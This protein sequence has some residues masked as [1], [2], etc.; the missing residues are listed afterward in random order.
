MTDERPSPNDGD[1]PA[2]TALGDAVR[3]LREGQNLSV[4]TLAR[5]SGF[6]PS[7]ISQV[8]HGLASPSIASMEKIARALGVSMSRFFAGTAATAD[9]PIIVRAG[10]GEEL[11]SAWSHA[12][13]RALSEAWDGRRLAPVIL[14]VDPG[15]RSGGRPTSHQGEEFAYVLLGD[16]ALRLADEVQTLHIG[17]AVHLPPGAEHVWENPGDSP[18]MLLLVTSGE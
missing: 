13:V 11:D 4:R 18:V 7:F 2:A 16:V 5:R 12:R 9:R 10:Q 14:T 15:G 17:D 1:T 8:E 6:S 3:S